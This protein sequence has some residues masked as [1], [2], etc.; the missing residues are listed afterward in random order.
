[1]SKRKHAE[2][3]ALEAS[4]P[5]SAPSLKKQR[6]YLVSALD[7]A[8]KSLFRA[9]R[10]ARGF[11]RQKL[12]RRQKSSKTKKGAKDSER[13][14]GEVAALKKLDLTATAESYL[15]KTLVRTKAVSEHAALPEEVR[16]KALALGQTPLD[17]AAANVVARLCKTGPVVEAMDKVLVEVR[18]ALGLREEEVKA[19][20]RLRRA[21]YEAAS[22]KK[23]SAGIQT[24]ENGQDQAEAASE[25]HREDDNSFAGFS[26]DLASSSGTAIDF[27]SEDEDN[28]HPH[29]RHGSFNSED[30]DEDG[31]DFSQ[32]DSR[33]AGSS[34]QESD[35][36]EREDANMH[37]VSSRRA[38]STKGLPTGSA[39]LDTI[40]ISVSP[41]AS[42]EARAPAPA[43]AR[44]KVTSDFIPSLRTGY[45]SGS[46]SDASDISVLEAPRK[47]RL[48][49]RARQAKWEAKYGREAKHIKNG[50][51]IQ[52][53][54]TGWD[55]RRGATDGDARKPWERRRGTNSAGRSAER[56]P[57]RMRK[58]PEVEKIP[59]YG[60]AHP[61]WVARQQ[62][63]ERAAVAVRPAGKKIT[64]D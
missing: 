38:I 47:N 60:A 4:N 64:F 12:G 8:R 13:L 28:T 6:K 37:D 15:C 41:S 59:T 51:K 7:D 46:D 43:P 58:E 24:V 25:D 2:I 27:N 56:R 10:L 40:S 31:I 1:M 48:G 19:K 30:E 50:A 63:K 21:D 35:G 52:S 16:V 5:I 53:R 23:D 39:S 32:Y 3:D 11:E 29:I 42:P 36:E 57:E 44:N 55:A 14:D 54:D 61:S 18:R 45:L 49:Q 20:K 62:A 22:G 9:L 26:D 33:L 34:S 17:V